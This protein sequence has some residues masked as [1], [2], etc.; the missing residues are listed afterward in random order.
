MGNH[1]RNGRFL[2]DKFAVYRSDDGA[3]VSHDKLVLS[4]TDPAA[5]PAIKLFANTTRDADLAIDIK[6]R[7]RAIEAEAG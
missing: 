3:P 6:A 4:F 5:R 7:L 1:L 2:S